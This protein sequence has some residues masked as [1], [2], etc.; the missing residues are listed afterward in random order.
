M[1]K[2]E[3]V[4]VFPDKKSL[5]TFSKISEILLSV[6][7]NKIKILKSNMDPDASKILQTSWIK[8]YGLLAIACKEEVVMKVATLAGEPFG[9]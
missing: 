1:E 2:R 5:D 4:A 3:F 6:H 9:S 7:G 8:I